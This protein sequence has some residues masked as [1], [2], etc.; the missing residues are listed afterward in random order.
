MESNR[1]SVLSPTPPPLPSRSLSSPPLQTVNIN[2]FLRGSTARGGRRGGR[3]GRG[4]YGGGRGRG[5]YQAPVLIEDPSQ[6]PTLGAA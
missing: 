2:E 6:F 3:G 4:S 5:N 1:L